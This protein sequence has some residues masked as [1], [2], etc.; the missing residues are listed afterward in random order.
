M[1]QLLRRNLDSRIAI[2]DTFNGLEG[3]NRFSSMRFEELSKITRK[4]WR[5]FSY[6][7]RS[8]ILSDI[9][10]INGATAGKIE[11]WGKE[12]F[13][14]DVA[15]LKEEIDAISNVKQYLTD[16]EKLTLVQEAKDSRDS[17]RAHFV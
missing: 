13:D 5:G 7:K 16:G 6:E 14:D 10:V 8:D 1:Y 15:S 11:F 3:E 12:S 9:R 4:D 17:M 2:G